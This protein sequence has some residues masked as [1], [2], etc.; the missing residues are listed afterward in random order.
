MPFIGNQPTQGR[1]IELDSLSASAT[2]N[3]TLQ[4]NSAN[5]SPESVNNLLVSINGVIQGSSTMSLNGAVLT[6]GATLSSSDTIDF[7]R[8]FGNVGTITTPTDGSVT[9]N[10]IGSGAITNAKIADNAS[11]S[12][13]K[14]GTGAVIQVHTELTI[15]TLSNV[16]LAGQATALTASSGTLWHTCASFTPKF[17]NSKLL[18]QTSTI[19]AHESSNAGD[20]HFALVTDDSTLFARTGSFVSYQVWDGNLNSSFISFNHAFNSWGTSAKQLKIKFGVQHSSAKANQ[21]V[22]LASADNYAHASTRSIG[23]TIMEI[24]G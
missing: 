15:A 13:S 24:G 11:I 12:G 2:A 19:S 1:F 23:I 21:Y 10:K 18:F 6:V 3:Y 17:S 20:G 9:A 7:V 5:Y 14:L 16:T 8:V 22:N 4:L